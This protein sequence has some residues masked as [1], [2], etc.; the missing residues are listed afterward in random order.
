MCRR[1]VDEARA[2]TTVQA[3][4]GIKTFLINRYRM[5]SRAECLEHAYCAGISGLFHPHWCGRIEQD[6][7]GPIQGFLSAGHNQ[8]LLGGALYTARGIQVISHGLA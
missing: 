5:D 8:Y 3:T 7:P 6:A 1:D 4:L 2:W